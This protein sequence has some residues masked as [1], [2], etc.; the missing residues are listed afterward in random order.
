MRHRG[1]SIL[2]LVVLLLLQ[3]RAQETPREAPT[4]PKAAATTTRYALL[5]AGAVSR[6][7]SRRH[8]NMQQYTTAATLYAADQRPFFSS[9]KVCV[10]SIRRH[11][12]E[13]NPASW[14]VFVHSWHPDLEDTYRQAF[15]EAVSMA[16]EDN[17]PF[18]QSLRG[19]FKG[20]K[21]PAVS[22]SL[23]VGRVAMQLLQREQMH[24]PKQGGSGYSRVLL[25]RPDVF[26]VKNLDLAALPLGAIYCNSFGNAGGDFRFV[27]EPQHVP[28][29]VH[30]LYPHSTSAK[31]AKGPWYVLGDHNNMRNFMVKVVRVAY[32]NDGQIMAGEME[33]VYRKLNWGGMQ[34]SAPDWWEGFFGTYGMNTTDWWCIRKAFG[35]PH[36][37]AQKTFGQGQYILNR[38]CFNN[39]C[40]E[41]PENFQFPRRTLQDRMRYCKDVDGWNRES[42]PATTAPKVAAIP[43]YSALGTSSQQNMAV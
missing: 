12:L 18:E 5:V 9:V 30:A 7:P 16:F 27:M 39:T 14:D 40:K 28:E 24:G 13:A 42:D 26:M 10:A 35:M 34:C 23:S 38:C 3:S 32:R 33:D 31:E 25:M 4:S 21:W 41:L 22:F 8:G 43:L 6:L 1:H 17:R 11:I 37:E 36:C 29:L 20:E 19:V 15:P 2:Q